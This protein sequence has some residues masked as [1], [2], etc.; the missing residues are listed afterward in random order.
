MANVYEVDS[1]KLVS[2]AAMKLK[3]KGIAK[4][5]YLDYVKS[6]PSRER[7][8]QQKDFWYIRSAS[9]L[10][11]VY[12]SGPVGVSRLRTR[13]GSKKGHVVSRHHHM[14]AGGSIITDALNALEKAGYVKK[15]KQGREITP[16][17]RSLLDKVANE[18]TRGA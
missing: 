1:G 9:L 3:E 17:G 13:Y 10:R 15:G 14:R 4:P 16:S 18:L 12:V 8:P 11:Q 7:I 5:A 2:A 6:S